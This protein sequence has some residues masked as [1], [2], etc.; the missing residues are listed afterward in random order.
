MANFVT[1]AGGHNL[2]PLDNARTQDIER[3][4]REDEEYFQRT[5]INRAPVQEYDP[6]VSIGGRDDDIAD[7]ADTYIDND[8]GDLYAQTQI[9]R[10]VNPQEN[11]AYNRRNVVAK[12][13]ENQKIMKQL[14]E[15]EKE[16]RNPI[17]DLEL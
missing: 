13:I 9:I 3:R 14:K 10:N 17:L 6:L 15:S 2:D 7:D 1:R 11:E 8:P 12:E 5:G 4:I 16:H